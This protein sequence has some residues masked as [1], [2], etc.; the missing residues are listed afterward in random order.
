MPHHITNIPAQNIPE[1][2][3]TQ[4][5]TTD[6]SG[7]SQKPPFSPVG[8]GNPHLK[9]LM[10]NFSPHSWI[11]WFPKHG[12]TQWNTVSGFFF[13]F[14]GLTSLAACRENGLPQ[15]ASTR[16]LF[17]ES[18][19]VATSVTVDQP[20]TCAAQ[21]SRTTVSL[22]RDSEWLCFAGHSKTHKWKLFGNN[23][24]GILQHNK[25]RN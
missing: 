6:W 17:D 10:A 24:G 7:I 2:R 20:R 18:A 13:F 15:W 3:T 22:L 12:G 25:A 1:G 4:E 11:F 23:V 9:W 8:K 14:F 19:A 5:N 16:D 21:S